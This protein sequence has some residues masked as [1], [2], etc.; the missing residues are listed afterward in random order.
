MQ[1]R[2]G[3]AHITVSFGRQFKGF[4]REMRTIPP[5]GGVLQAQVHRNRTLHLGNVNVPPSR[6]AIEGSEDGGGRRAA[7]GRKKGPST[8]SS[9]PRALPGRKEPGQG[10]VASHGPCRGA[11]HLTTR[12]RDWEVCTPP[13]PISRRPGK[14]QPS[15]L[16]PIRRRPQHP[17]GAA[18]PNLHP[19][20]TIA[21]PPMPRSTSD[22]LSARRMKRWARRETAQ[23]NHRGAAQNSCCGRSEKS[24]G[25]GPA[26]S[27]HCNPQIAQSTSRWF[28]ACGREASAGSDRG[29]PSHPREERERRDRSA[30]MV[31]RA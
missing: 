26:E 2:G 17:R 11:N 3:L 8:T 15:T 19:Q 31:T 29:S 28:S 16:G 30:A 20:R 5:S 25:T 23:Q 27:S 9:A 18:P 4:G 13:V 21:H 7:S 1:R 24:V 6:P 14:A 22:P 10:V 12:A